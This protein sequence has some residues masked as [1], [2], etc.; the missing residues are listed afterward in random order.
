MAWQVFDLNEYRPGPVLRQI[1]AN[2]R[3]R[4]EAGDPMAR[5]VRRRAAPRSLNLCA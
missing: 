2:F 1:W 3:E 5:I 4:E